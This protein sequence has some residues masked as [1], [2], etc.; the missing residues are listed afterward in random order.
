MPFGPWEIFIILV[1]LVVIFGA[2]RLSQVGGAMGKSVREFR[3][4]VREEP[5]PAPAPVPAAAPVVAVAAPPVACPECQTANPATNRFCSACGATM[6]GAAASSTATHVPEPAAGPE[7]PGLEA[8]PAAPA[9]SA[10]A[11][12]LAEE[13]GGVMHGPVPVPTNTCPSCATLNPPGQPFC[14]QCGT[15]LKTAAA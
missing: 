5:A 14:G 2:G 4:A 11:T 1:I 6:T 3:G 9:T 8:A 10:P 7:Q 13:D 15:R 12:P